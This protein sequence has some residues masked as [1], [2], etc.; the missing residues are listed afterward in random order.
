MKKVVLILALT[1]LTYTATFACTCADIPDPLKDKV[2]W[3]LKDSTAVFTGESIKLE[4]IPQTRDM[5][6]TFSV[7]EFWK[8]DLSGVV[9]LRTPIDSASCGFDFRIGRSYLVYAYGPKTALMTGLCGGNREQYDARDQL[10]VLGRGKQPKS[11]NP[12]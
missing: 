12:E 3:W 6:V 10:E 1:G 8:G 5:V 7:D 9:E 4:K 11:K 2:A